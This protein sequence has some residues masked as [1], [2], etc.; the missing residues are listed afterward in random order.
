MKIAII[1]IAIV[2][3]AVVLYAILGKTNTTTQQGGGGNTDVHSGALGWLKGILSG[4]NIK[5]V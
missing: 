2:V 4:L 3:F 5:L 1:A